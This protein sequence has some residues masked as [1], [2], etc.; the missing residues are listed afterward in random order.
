VAIAP[1]RSEIKQGFDAALDA[2]EADGTIEKLRKK[3]FTKS[4]ET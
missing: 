2:L 1:G 3:W 4:T